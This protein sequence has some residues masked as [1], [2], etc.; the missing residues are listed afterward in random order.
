MLKP[1]VFR[2][3]LDGEVVEVKTDG[4]DYVAYEAAYG[5]SAV[6]DI[7]EL[8]YTAWCHVVWTALT[9]DGKVTG[10]FDEFLASTPSIAP[11]PEAQDLD[12]LE[13]T[14]PTGT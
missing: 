8:H 13:P 11:N 9:R 14:Q 1:V 6:T 3:D 10:S 5:R 4:R 7:A 12:P 2:L